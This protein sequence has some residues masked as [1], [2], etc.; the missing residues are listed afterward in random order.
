M[1]YGLMKSHINLYLVDPKHDIAL[2]TLFSILVDVDVDVDTLLITC[3]L[4]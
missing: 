4:C 1:D 3:A 2:A